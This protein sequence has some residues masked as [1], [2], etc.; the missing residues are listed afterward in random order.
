MRLYDGI[1]AKVEQGSWLKRK[2]FQKA[3]NSKIQNLRTKGE[4]K[5][6]FYDKLI[7]SKI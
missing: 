6:A 1:K 5:S 3:L 7:F 2:I 4:L